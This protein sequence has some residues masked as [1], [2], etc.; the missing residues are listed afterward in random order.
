MRAPAPPFWNSSGS[1]KPLRGGLFISHGESQIILFVFRWRALCD[2]SH[3]R[4]PEP[5]CATDL[6]LDA[7]P[8]RRK[9]KGNGGVCASPYKQATPPGFGIQPDSS[10]S[11][12]STGKM[13]VMIRASAR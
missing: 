13:W 5:D 2:E 1:F 9:T 6:E 3:R 8:R 7:A 11:Y 10:P 4:L 12:L